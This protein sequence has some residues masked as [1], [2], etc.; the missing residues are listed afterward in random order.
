M[1]PAAC[2]N[3]TPRGSPVSTTPAAREAPTRTG[4]SAAAAGGKTPS[5]DFGHAEHRGRAANIRS[6]AS[7][8]SKPPPRHRPRTI[9]AVGAGTASR[10]RT[11]SC[12]SARTRSMSRR[13]VFLDARAVAEVIAGALD[14]DQLECRSR[15]T[16]ASASRRALASSAIE[17]MF[18]FGRSMTSRRWPPSSRVSERTSSSVPP[19]ARASSAFG[20]M[21]SVSSSSHVSP[22][23]RRRRSSTKSTSRCPGGPSLNARKPAFASVIM[24]SASQ[25]RLVS[26]LRCQCSSFFFRRLSM[27]LGQ[28]VGHRVQQLG[29]PARDRRR[30]DG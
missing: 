29:R 14:R 7:A 26:Q 20:S 3:G 12:S 17:T 4:R 27:R 6:Q 23:A 10:S 8:T 19:P 1:S 30:R 15:D 21:A 5:D 13:P 11:R 25:L 16:R 24:F 22:R 28:A 18:A 9:A 2:Q